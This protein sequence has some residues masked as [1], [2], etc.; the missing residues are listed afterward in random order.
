MILPVSDTNELFFGVSP[1]V[2]KFSLETQDSGGGLRLIDARV[3]AIG[4]SMPRENLFEF[5]PLMM[6]T[7]I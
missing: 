1:Y 2:D 6:D 5:L 4:V 3:K 7:Q